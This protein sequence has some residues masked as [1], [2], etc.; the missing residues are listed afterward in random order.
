MS[1]K[2]VMTNQKMED[3][4]LF[5]EFHGYGQKMIVDK[6]PNKKVWIGIEPEDPLLG[7]DIMGVGILFHPRYKDNPKFYFKYR[8]AIPKEL[9]KEAEAAMVE[10]VSFTDELLAREQELFALAGIDIDALE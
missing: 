2:I 4:H 1:N 8:N 3:G 7:I 10:A 5:T 9:W 6:R